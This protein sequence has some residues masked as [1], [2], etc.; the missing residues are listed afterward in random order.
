MMA[1]KSTRRRSR[2]ESYVGEDQTYVRPLG[3]HA[4]DRLRNYGTKMTPG[5]LPRR[6]IS[7]T[8]R[9]SSSSSV[10]SRPSGISKLNRSNTS[11]WHRKKK[12]NNKTFNTRSRQTAA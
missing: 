6:G 3:K 12:N 11:L 8:C 10:G 5:G 2:T 1:L 9:I 4:K 7:F